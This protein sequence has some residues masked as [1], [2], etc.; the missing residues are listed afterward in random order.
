M[1]FRF[2]VGDDDFCRI[3]QVA[4]EAEY[5]SPIIS[6]SNIDAYP[7]ELNLDRYTI[8]TQTAFDYAES[9]VWLCPNTNEYY[10]RGTYAVGIT[11]GT[12]TSFVLKV[13]ASSQVLPLPQPSVRIDC[14]DVPDDELQYVN[15]ICV[16]DSVTID[17][18][19]VQENLISLF[20]VFGPKCHAFFRIQKVQQV[21][22]SSY[23]FRLD[24]IRYPSQ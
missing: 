4:A 16:E 1:Y 13:T 7:N 14:N 17:L 21:M 15:S 2:F 3:I 9:V 11:G 10:D 5:G 24:V 19:Q 12:P 20:W 22:S 18:F 6:V 8:S 23:P